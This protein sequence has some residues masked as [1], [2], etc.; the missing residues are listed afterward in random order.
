[1]PDVRLICDASGVRLDV[2]VSSRNDE[3]SRSFYKQLIKDGKVK[4]NGNIPSKSGT[5]KLEE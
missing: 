1:M 4:V 2:Y 3:Y 5:V